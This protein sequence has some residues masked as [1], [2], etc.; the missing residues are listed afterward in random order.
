MVVAA[1]AGAAGIVVAVAAVLLVDH[2]ACSSSGR[3]PVR[4]AG[5]K[6]RARVTTVRRMQKQTTEE[7]QSTITNLIEKNSLFPT[8]GTRK[9]IHSVRVQL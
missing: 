7:R 9:G 6:T 5:R 4:E 2:T 8:T 3:R 1:A